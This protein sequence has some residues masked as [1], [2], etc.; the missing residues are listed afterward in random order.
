ML[1]FPPNQSDLLVRGDDSRSHLH[2]RREAS[3]SEQSRPRHWWPLLD[4]LQ[5]GRREAASLSEKLH[6]CVSI[7]IWLHASAAGVVDGRKDR[8]GH[9]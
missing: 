5:R 9:R 8:R 6:L 2:G 7:Y 3:S 1:P 4:R